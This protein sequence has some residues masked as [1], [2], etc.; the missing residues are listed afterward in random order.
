MVA[1]SEKITESIV[2]ISA[3]T[4]EF[5]VENSLLTAKCTFANNQTQTNI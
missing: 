3:N 4:A 1:N 2:A 5:L